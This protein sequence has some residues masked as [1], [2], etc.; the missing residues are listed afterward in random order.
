M[1]SQEQFA[2]FE[3]MCRARFACREGN[4]ILAGRSGAVETTPRTP[5]TIRTRK[6]HTTHR[7]QR[8]QL[9]KLFAV[10]ISLTGWLPWFVNERLHRLTLKSMT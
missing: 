6:R 5:R 1:N 2:A 3:F 4:G 7:L 8:T 10:R 9:D